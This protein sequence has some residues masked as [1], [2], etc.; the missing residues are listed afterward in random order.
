MAKV[1]WQRPAGLRLD[2]ALEQ[3]LRLI[4]DLI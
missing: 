3:N 4:R 1:E 2:D